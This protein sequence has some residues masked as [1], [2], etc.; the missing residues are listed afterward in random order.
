VGVPLVADMLFRLDSGDT[1]GLSKRS[2]RRIV[3]PPSLSLSATRAVP[4]GEVGSE[5]E[6]EPDR[7]VRWR[8]LEMMEGMSAV[9]QVPDEGDGRSS[10]RSQ[11]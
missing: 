1:G 9:Q 2:S 7:D 11:G 6:G 10:R 4:E 3:L 8:I 5:G